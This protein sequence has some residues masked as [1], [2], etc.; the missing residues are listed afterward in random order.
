LMGKNVYA[1]WPAPNQRIA[2]AAK[3]RREEVH[4]HL[5]RL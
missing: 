4:P 5:D 1:A 3:Y 2:I